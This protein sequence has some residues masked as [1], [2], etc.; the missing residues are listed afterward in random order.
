MITQAAYLFQFK[1]LNMITTTQIDSNAADSLFRMLDHE[2]KNSI[3]PDKFLRQLSGAGIL[4]DD[5]RIREL[6]AWP[7]FRQQITKGNQI[8][9]TEFNE[10]LQQNALVKKSLSKNLVIPDFEVFCQQ[11]QDI[12]LDTQRNKGGKVADYIPQLARVDPEQFAI[13]ICTVDGQRYSIGD[14]STDFCLQS[15]CKPIN[16]CLALEELGEE[17]VHTH[18]GREPSGQSFNE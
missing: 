7:Q 6:L 4:Q 5:P 1:K 18:V 17:K 8:A 2:G 14:S 16:Y 10:I 13:S 15:S 11:I 3:D 9:K 12:F